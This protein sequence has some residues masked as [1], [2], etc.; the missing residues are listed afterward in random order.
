MPEG[1]ELADANEIL[2]CDRV[3]EFIHPSGERTPALHSDLFRYEVLRRF[4]GWYFDLDVVLVIDEPPQSEFYLA[5]EDESVINGAIMR[6]PPVSEIMTAA[7]ERAG[8][9]VDSGKWGAVGPALITKL[10][11]EFGITQFARPW[12]T[13]FPIRPTE[14]PLLFLP[15]HCN[16]VVE[17]LANADFLHFWHEIWRQV[18]IPKA[19][20]PPTGSFLDILFRRFDIP[21]AR[22][23]RLSADAIRS[24]FREFGI[25]QEVRR[26]YAQTDVEC[27]LRDFDTLLA[28]KARYGDVNPLDILHERDEIL[29]STSWRLSAPLRLCVTAYRRLCAALSRAAGDRPRSAPDED[30]GRSQSEGMLQIASRRPPVTTVRSL[31]H[32]IRPQVFLIRVRQWWFYKMPPPIML[33]TMLFAAEPA[34]NVSAIDI[35]RALLCLI[36]VIALVCNFGYALN[37]LYD[38]EED[39]KKGKPNTMGSLGAPKLWLAAGLSAAGSLLAALVWIGATAFVLTLLAQFLSLAYSAPPLRLKERKWLGV[40]ADAAAAHIYPALLCLLILARNVAYG[41]SEWLVITVVLWS[42]AFGLRGFLTHLVLD[43]ELDRAAGLTTIVHHHGR[44]FVI[45]L[46]ARCITPLEIGCFI[47]VAMQTSAGTIFYAVVCVYLLFEAFKV[48]WRWKSI[49]FTRGTLSSYIPFLNNSFYEVWG[50][51]GAALAAAAKDR[52]LLVLPLALVVLFWS[53]IHTEWEMIDVLSRGIAHAGI[54][55]AR[56]GV[57]HLGS[58]ITRLKR[59]HRDVQ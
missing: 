21:V 15:E 17:R 16:E 11:Q 32:D 47:L 44:E 22:D 1:I 31:A 28:I 10:A 37:E 4:G 18:R 51:L 3:H 55:F 24:W 50:P 48:Y 36:A 23:A 33:L 42:L 53:R 13:A 52:V 38:V 41:P 7:S 14:V 30:S 34:G 46:L 35:L 9:L 6:F 5:C 56:R 40:L 20:G 27:W 12:P 49:I 59:T 8:K 29:G 57:A 43:D 26:R 25:L 54:Q 58:R 45:D 2:P 39:A 19:Y